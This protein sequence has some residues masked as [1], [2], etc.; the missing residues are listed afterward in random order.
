[1]TRVLP[2]GSQVSD[3]FDPESCEASLRTNQTKLGDKSSIRVWLSETVTTEREWL[4][5]S[6]LI[7]SLRSV[8]KYR[9]S[10]PVARR[11]YEGLKLRE[12]GTENECC[13]GHLAKQALRL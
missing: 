8:A 1:M 5:S 2:K 9:N 6:S 7:G 13:L 11:L 4:L 3:E 12:A 10:S